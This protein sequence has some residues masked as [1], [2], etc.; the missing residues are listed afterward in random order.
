MSS[1]RLTHCAV[2]VLSLELFVAITLTH[3]KDVYLLRM[4]VRINLDDYLSWRKHLEQPS[5][6]PNVP[7][8]KRFDEYNFDNDRKFQLG[9]PSIIGQLIKDGKSTLDKAALQKEMTKA[10]AF[11]YARYVSV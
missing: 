3:L 1:D 6:D 8:F 2:Y 7:I 4:N 11:Y 10:K 9:L 5:D